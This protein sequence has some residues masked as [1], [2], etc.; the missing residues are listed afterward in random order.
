M[1]KK[2]K[3]EKMLNQ[4]EIKRVFDQVMN[5]W[6]IPEIERRKR[7]GILKNDFEIKRVQVIFTIGKPPEIKFNENV[8]ITAMVKANRDIIKGEEVKYSDVDKF[9][10]FIAD[11]PPNSGHITL[12]KLLD[13]WI[14]ILDARYN[15]E[16]IGG[17][18]E[19]SKEFYES[20]KEDLKENR[21][22]PFYENCWNSAELSA[23]CHSLG[24]GGKIKGHGENIKN[25][26]KWSELENVDKKHAE[27]LSQ[28]KDLRKSKYVSSIDFRNKDHKEFLK[29]VKEMIEEAERLIKNN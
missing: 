25:F 4:E 2:K 9:E 28:L 26:V 1:D 18:I 22:R 20:A 24:I 5:I 7:K 13:H 11:Y 17:L 10:K 15:K 16:K 3:E 14:I 21:L 8:G 27:I 6:A 29:V 23:V 12:F 19:R